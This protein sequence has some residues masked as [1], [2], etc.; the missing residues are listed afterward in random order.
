MALTGPDGAKQYEQSFDV[1]I[2]GGET[3]GQLLVRDIALPPV[4][5]HGYAELTA[6]LTGRSGGIAVEGADDIFAVDMSPGA[7]P[8]QFSETNDWVNS[9]VTDLD[10]A[11]DLLRLLT[12]WCF[13]LNNILRASA[14]LSWGLARKSGWNK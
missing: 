7:F 13:Q 6:R 1:R 8:E 3:Y 11:R 12:R 2:E 4:G 5:M 10:S 14:K 9:R